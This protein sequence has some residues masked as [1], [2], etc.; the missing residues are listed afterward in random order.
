[1]FPAVKNN[2]AAAHKAPVKTELLRGAGLLG[3]WRRGGGGG[4]HDE[5]GCLGSLCDV[6]MQR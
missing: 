3:S 4:D 1:M 6:C 5:A 2:T